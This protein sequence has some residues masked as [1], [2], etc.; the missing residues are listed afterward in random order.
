M[1]SCLDMRLCRRE[2][3]RRDRPSTATCSL[4]EK[5]RPSWDY[6]DVRSG[7]RG[8]PGVG[9][10]Q[11]LRPR[12]VTRASIRQPQGRYRATASHLYPTRLA[13]P[14]SERHQ[15]WCRHH[16]WLLVAGLQQGERHGLERLE[17]PPHSI[18]CFRLQIFGS[19]RQDV[20]GWKK[21][22]KK[23]ALANPDHRSACLASPSDILP[24][25]PGETHLNALALKW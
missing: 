13:P 3:S 17:H 6:E 5:H 1:G 10:V 14:Y 12:S 11:V 2:K 4:C 24:C 8:W 16:H 7:E 22:R 20:N 23:F 9:N 25:A 18:P 19:A 15:G 21:R